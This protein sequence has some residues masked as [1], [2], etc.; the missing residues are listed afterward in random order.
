MSILIN[1][2][3]LSENVWCDA[4]VESD[5]VNPV[6]PEG[7]EFD[8]IDAYVKEAWGSGWYKSRAELGDWVEVLDIRL[9]EIVDD[10]PELYELQFDEYIYENFD[11]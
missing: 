9:N 8:I 11:D 3:E 7:P 2:V 1:D 4:I 6:C 5:C 10:I